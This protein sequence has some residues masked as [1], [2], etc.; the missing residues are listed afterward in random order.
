MSKRILAVVLA[1]VMAMSLLTVNV[2]ALTDFTIQ[3]TSS[4]AANNAK[5]VTA[6]WNKN[7]GTNADYYLV[8]VTKGSETLPGQKDVKVKDEKPAG[9]Y[10]HIFTASTSGTYVVTVYAYKDGNASPIGSG[11]QSIDIFIPQ[12]LTG[13]N[14]LKLVSTSNNTV[15]VTW[16]A[17]AGAASYYIEWTY[18]NG[19]NETTGGNADVPSAKSTLSLDISSIRSFKVYQGTQNSHLTT[20]H[21]SGA[22]NGGTTGSTG[23][24]SQ[25]STTGSVSYSNG[26]LSWTGANYVTIVVNAGYQYVTSYTAQGTSTYFANALS[27]AVSANPYSVI[28]VYVYSGNYTGSN[29]NLLGTL[30]YNGYSYGGFGYGLNITCTPYVQSGYIAVA[31]S[32]VSGA[33]SYVVNYSVNGSASQSQYASGT[34]YNI[35][36]SYGQQ[37]T[38]NVWAQ[39]SNGLT[40]AQS[41]NA[42]VSATGT[43]SYSGGGYAGV[44]GGNAVS[45]NNCVL[46][47]GSSSTSVQLYSGY[48]VGSTYALVTVNGSTQQPIVVY[49]NPFT[50]NVGSNTSFS[51]IV[52]NG[53]SVIAQASYTATS[54][55]AS[56]LL[57][58]NSKTSYTRGI[59]LKAKNSSTTTVSWDA[60][61]NAAYYEYNYLRTG[62]G[63]VITATTTKTSFDVPFGKA[64][65]FEVIVYAY[66]NNRPK[67]VGEA[68]HIA[69][70]NVEAANAVNSSSSNSSSSKVSAYV[71][72]LKGTVG[73]SGSI[74]LAWNA[75]SG[76]PN[77]EVW[78]KKSTA[79]TWKKVYTTSGRA[80]KVNKLSNGTSYD[81]KV[82]ANGR[83]SGILTMTIG[84]TSSTKT[85][86]DPEGVGT[87]T[88]AVPVIT[89]ISGGNGSITVSWSP[90]TGATK[91]QVWVNQAGTTTY[92]K[93]ATVDGTSATITGLKAGS[94]KVRIKA[95]K[96]GTTWYTF[97][98]SNCIKSDYRTVDVK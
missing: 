91:Y 16:N 31:W 54:S 12:T 17:I 85:A 13:S 3:C 22:W 41:G 73:K 66:V 43:V 39:N 57:N 84:T 19:K 42:V 21:A 11:Q 81:F 78:Y 56:S 82:V 25:Y 32:P 68:L 69:G 86:P 27:S 15:D 94:Y 44:T 26:Y 45:G 96:D 67:E 76:N 8:T 97:N 58:S 70:D 18:V 98:D 20:V 59:T 87:T 46:Y 1:L 36:W 35:P 14:G 6:E 29:A 62:I 64:V 5:T 95:S 28:T 63:S 49:S 92:T 71:T 55:S 40:I 77:Y 75:A 51:V 72:G 61:P 23:T 50:I 30:T 74:T 53:S 34:S 60:V 93:K 89:S 9:K 37:V 79:S 48:T 2:F 90:A 88:S 65:G 52:Y 33:A 80:L 10:Q 38:I 7:N 4:D 47:V 24:G 83:D